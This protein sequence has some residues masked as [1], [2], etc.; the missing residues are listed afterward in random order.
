MPENSTRLGP[1]PCANPP[2]AKRMRIDKESGVGA[3]RGS[4]LRGLGVVRP[5]PVDRRGSDR[6]DHVECL[7][8]IGWKTFRRFH[9]NHA[10]IINLSRGGAQIF[11]DVPPPA[12]RPIWVFLETPGQNAVVKAKVRETCT[13]SQGQC[14][15][16]VEFSQ[17]C[18]YAF[19][20]AAVCGLP[21]SDPKRRIA[22]AHKALAG[23]NTLGRRTAG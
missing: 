3:I 18:P 9:T 20:E 2:C 17:P 1:E 13:T 14:M 16:R 21:A 22:P 15:I 12:G 19:F 8:W 5:E 6:H 4:L 7:A 10:L 23:M 11:V